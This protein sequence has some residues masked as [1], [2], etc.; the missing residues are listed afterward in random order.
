MKKLRKIEYY[1]SDKYDPQAGFMDSRDDNRT[2]IGL[3]HRFADSYHI[4]NGR[5][6]P[7]TEAIIED[8]KTGEIS[9]IK[10]N[11]IIRFV[12]E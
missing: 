6:Y 8:E 1:T 11:R 12:N 10:C 7:L 4:D 5:Y 9:R 3:F 2:A